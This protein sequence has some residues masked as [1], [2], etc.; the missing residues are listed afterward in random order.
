MK[1]DSIQANTTELHIA[2]VIPVHFGDLD[3]RSAL[4]ME[5]QFKQLSIGDDYQGNFFGDC[6]LKGLCVVGKG[7]WKDREVGKS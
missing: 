3:S 4:Q 2:P 1:T 5:G 6:R 7:S